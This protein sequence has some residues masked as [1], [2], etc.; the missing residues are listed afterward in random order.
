MRMLTPI[1][2]RPAVE[3][4]E[5]TIRS[6]VRAARLVPTNLHWYRFLVAE[7]GGRVVAM[8]QVKV[9]KGGTREV[10]SGMVLPEYRRRGISAR[11]MH[12][13]LDHEHGPLY[14][15]CQEK[16]A[17]Y[18]ERFGFRR[19][20]PSELPVD[21]RK[22]YRIGKIIVAIRF[23]FAWRKPRFIPMKRDGDRTP[24]EVLET[25]HQPGQSTPLG[26]KAGATRSR[27]GGDRIA[28]DE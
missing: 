17:R 15:R 13:L 25:L 3:A 14:L 2:I 10:A 21:L 18:Y 5:A 20:E 8:R 9:H 19:V 12:A 11:L 1:T 28:V 27:N 24:Y 22:D 16:W 6:M 4:D 26:P 7:D 23:L